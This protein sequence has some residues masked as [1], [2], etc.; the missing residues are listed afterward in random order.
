[1]VVR[2]GLVTIAVDPHKRLNAVEVMDAR[3][4]VVGQQ[5]FTH[6]SAGFKEVMTFARSW[7]TRRWA[8]EGA[9]GVGKNLAAPGHHRRGR[10][11]CAEQE[12]VVGAGVLGDVGP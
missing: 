11:R 1:M 2:T 9:T 8:V 3:G 12:V 7:R 5:V 6:S 4:R 10:L